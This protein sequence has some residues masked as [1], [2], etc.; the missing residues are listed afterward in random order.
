MRGHL[1]TRSPW[2]SRWLYSETHK[3][4]SIT[5]TAVIR[6]L[7]MLFVLSNMTRPSR[8]PSY[9]LVTAQRQLA[10]IASFSFSS[11]S[12]AVRFDSPTLAGPFL[13]DQPFYKWQKLQK[14]LLQSML[15]SR[16]QAKME[17]GCL[18]H[19]HRYRQETIHPTSIP[20][21]TNPQNKVG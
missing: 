14:L 7:L 19:Y 17:G 8:S 1:H 3:Y 2:T 21:Y 20:E 15:P 6:R 9:F 12:F 10:I 5:F 11:R 18:Q 4:T 13:V 16:L